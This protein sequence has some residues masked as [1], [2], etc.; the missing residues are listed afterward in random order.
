MGEG[1]RTHCD[2]VVKVDEPAARLFAIGGNVRGTVGLKAMPVARA[3]GVLRVVAP[4]P[5]RG[6][7]PIFAHLK[8]AETYAAA[9][10]FDASPAVRALGCGGPLPSAWGAAAGLVGRGDLDCAR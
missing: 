6:G 8:L 2:I 1:A 9:D 10:P 7:R 5:D 3:R 4:P